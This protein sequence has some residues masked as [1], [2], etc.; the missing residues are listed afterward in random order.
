MRNTEPNYTILAIKGTFLALVF[1]AQWLF[2]MWGITTIQVSAINQGAEN[3]A[4]T[5]T[6]MSFAWMV[7]GPIM[8]VYLWRDLMGIND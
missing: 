3:V 7:L 1:A 5:L 4:I 8:L 2:G 6:V